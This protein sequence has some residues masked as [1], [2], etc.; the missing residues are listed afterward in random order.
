MT[1]KWIF[2]TIPRYGHMHFPSRGAYRRNVW[3]QDG[4]SRAGSYCEGFAGVTAPQRAALLWFYNHHLKAIDDAQGTPFDT[5]N[6]YP[7]HAILAFV[8]WP[9]GPQ[10]RDPAEVLPRAVGDQT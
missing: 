8:N 6:P 10:E 3:D 9:F 1:L 4:I 5:P 2:L 7:H